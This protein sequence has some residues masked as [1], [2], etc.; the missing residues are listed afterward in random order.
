MT[1]ILRGSKQLGPG[2]PAPGSH[3]SLASSEGVCHVTHI[4]EYIRMTRR[5][6][7]RRSTQTPYRCF[8]VEDIRSINPERQAKLHSSEGSSGGNSGRQPETAEI[9]SR[10]AERNPA[11]PDRLPIDPKC[12]GTSVHP[13]R[14]PPDHP[15]I[16]SEPA[17]PP[18][19]LFFVFLPLIPLFPWLWLSARR[20]G[21]RSTGSL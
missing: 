16:L 20:N 7:H 10:K 19:C 6:L 1:E 14:P 18:F 3:S 8:G 21:F 11:S 17:C 15:T 2:S 4:S 5:L 12:S 13:M 9:P